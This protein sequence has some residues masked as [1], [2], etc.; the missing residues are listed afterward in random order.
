MAAFQNGAQHLSPHGKAARVGADQY[1]RVE[2][3]SQ[4]IGL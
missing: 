4:T 3:D 1:G 2:Y